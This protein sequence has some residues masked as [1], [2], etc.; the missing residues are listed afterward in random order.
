MRH[1]TATREIKR[2]TDEMG[3][4]NQDAVFDALGVSQL[5]LSSFGADGTMVINIYRTDQP[6]YQYAAIIAYETDED[7][8]LI[9]SFDALVQ[10][11]QKMTPMLDMAIK[12]ADH[13]ALMGR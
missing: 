9:Q 13:R 7:F 10:W 2:H 1:D 6:E 3:V 8:L 4:T 11:M 5:P 12:T